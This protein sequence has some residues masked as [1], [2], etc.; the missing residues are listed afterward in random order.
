MLTLST[1]TNPTEAIPKKSLRLIQILKVNS[2]RCNL[3]ME[4]ELL[5]YSDK[6]PLLSKVRFQVH[7]VEELGKRARASI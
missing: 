3:R 2:Q 7:K 4:V 6:L 1:L 5:S